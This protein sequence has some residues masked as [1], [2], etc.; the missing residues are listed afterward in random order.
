MKAK[1][2][3]AVLLIATVVV[4]LVA[5]RPEEPIQVVGSLSQQEISDIRKAVWTKTHPPILPKLSTQALLAAPG[6]LLKRYT[7]SVPAIVKM[8][9]RNEVFVA[10]FGR[11]PADVQTQQYYFWCVFKGPT[12]WQADAE[13][14]LTEN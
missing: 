1:L 13:Y 5:P 4:L 14:H 2:L 8:E 9:A 12:G 7:T 11:S 3:V 6:K 10:V